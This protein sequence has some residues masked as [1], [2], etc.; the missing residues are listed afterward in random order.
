MNKTDLIRNCHEQKG[1]H[2]GKFGF[3]SENNL[4]FEESK[5][6]EILGKLQV[7]LGKTQE[8]LHKIINED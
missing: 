6:V 1:K 2:N 5:E 8:E 4:M 7:K 3:L